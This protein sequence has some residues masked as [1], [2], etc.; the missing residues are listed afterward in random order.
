MN[1]GMLSFKWDA[2]AILNAE[3]YTQKVHVAHTFCMRETPVLVRL[4]RIACLIGL[5]MWYLQTRLC[6]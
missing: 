5:Q 3:C 6:D 2:A 4:N 1:E